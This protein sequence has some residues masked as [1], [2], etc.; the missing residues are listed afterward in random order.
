LLKPCELFCILVGKR[1]FHVSIITHLVI[2][3]K[4]QYPDLSA[5]VISGWLCGEGDCAAVDG[6]MILSATRH[7]E[8]VLDFC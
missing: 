8:V 7:I 5:C 2:N 1:Q 3:V 4:R 6:G